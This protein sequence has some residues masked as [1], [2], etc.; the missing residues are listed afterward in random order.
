LFEFTLPL[1]NQLIASVGEVNLSVF[2]DGLPDLF[3]MLRIVV[4]IE[5]C[6]EI[7]NGGLLS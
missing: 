3:W 2:A 1:V 5:L 4:L 6:E 7:R